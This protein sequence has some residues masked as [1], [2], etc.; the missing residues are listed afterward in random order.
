MKNL[1]LIAGLFSLT[2]FSNCGQ[3]ASH[4]NT[5]YESSSSYSKEEKASGESIKKEFKVNPGG[6]LDVKLHTGGSIEI[7]GWDKDLISVE[8]SQK[9]DE[10][11][12]E[13]NQQ[14]NDLTITSE[15][16][17]RKNNHS[18]SPKIFI[19]VPAKYNSKFYSL[20]GAI[21]VAGVEGKIEGS[22]MGGAIDIKNIKGVLD[23]KTMGG[24]IKITDSEAEGKAKTMGGE[25]LVENVKGDIDASSMGGKVR[26]INVTGKN[27]SVGKEIDIHT[28]GGDLDIDTAP[29]GA[30]LKTMGGDI[31][32]NS[33]SKFLDAETMGGDIFVKKAEGTVKVKTMGGDIEINMP[34]APEEVKDVSLTSLG[35]DV[36]LSIPEGASVVFDI[37]IELTRGHS[38]NP[39]VISDFKINENRTTDWEYK[40]G[41]DRK[42]IYGSGEI[43]GGKYKIK[44]RNVNGNVILKKS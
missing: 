6:N 14:G 24:S 38:D 9:R 43:N 39:K 36:T 5:F 27:K 44:I 4:E 2:L 25:V 19:N 7:K 17:E 29:S 23:V 18:R 37:D 21:D 22:T 28:M 13:F 12:F 16:M 33:V 15:Y 3:S 20:G 35:G 10:V 1:L 30:K 40:H 8:I 11:F 42:H 34:C 31:N 32:V 41:Q 26:H